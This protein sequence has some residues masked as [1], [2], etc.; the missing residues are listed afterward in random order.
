LLIA[1]PLGITIGY[2][3]CAGFVKNIGWRWSFYITAMLLFPCLV[4]LLLMPDKYLNSQLCADL[5]KK[6]KSKNLKNKKNDIDKIRSS[7]L[8]ILNK[9]QYRQVSP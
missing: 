9:D 2:G 5:Q 1:A 6:M 3:I 7:E 8:E 4:G